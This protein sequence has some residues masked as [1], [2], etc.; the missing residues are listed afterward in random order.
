MKKKSI[1]KKAIPSLNISFLLSP[2]GP[3]ALFRLKTQ[4]ENQTKI[5]VVVVVVV[6]VAAVV[7][8]AALNIKG[9]SRIVQ[10]NETIFKY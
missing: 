4:F 1:H 9:L 7:V 6:V 2:R 10:N 8:A 3:G 5:A